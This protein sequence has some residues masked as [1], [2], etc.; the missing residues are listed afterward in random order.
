MK[1]GSLT[2]AEPMFGN[3]EENI[4]VDLINHLNIRHC[5]IVGEETSTN[6][7]SKIFKKISKVNAYT[8]IKT[9]KEFFVPELYNSR[10]E[11]KTM[12]VY[13]SLNNIATMKNN[14]SSKGRKVR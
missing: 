5:Y 7:T 2:T 11:R 1:D 8:V 14:F 4:I 13:K 12:I 10:F 3:N 9:E 6:M